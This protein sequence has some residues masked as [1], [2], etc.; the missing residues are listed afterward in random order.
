MSYVIAAQAGG[1]DSAA[2][3]AAG[4]PAAIWV[5]IQAARKAG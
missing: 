1:L 3:V 2:M 5:A 4:A